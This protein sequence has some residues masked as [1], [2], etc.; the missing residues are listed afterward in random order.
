MIEISMDTTAIQ[1]LLSTTAVIA[2]VQAQLKIVP[3]VARALDYGRDLAA[4]QRNIVDT[5]RAGQ[6]SLESAVVCNE[7]NPIERRLEAAEY[8]LQ[9]WNPYPFDPKARLALRRAGRC[10]RDEIRRELPMAWLTAAVQSVRSL[11][12]RRIGRVWIKDAANQRFKLSLLKLNVEHFLR[13][14]RTLGIRTHEQLAL[15]A[16]PMAISRE[17]KDLD[18]C[19]DEQASSRIS[20]ALSFGDLESKLSALSPR[21]WQLWQLLSQGKSKASAARLMNISPST[22]RVLF[23]R[24]KNKLRN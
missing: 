1:G 12:P 7:H 21:E 18:A 6:I 5:M 10:G 17:L 20:D 11:K 15:D 22:A 3:A 23:W 16:A 24:I 2:R 14:L 4:F 8:L 9:L 13:A 19:S